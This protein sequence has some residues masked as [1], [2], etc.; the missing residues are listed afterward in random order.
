MRN[1]RC[2]EYYFGSSDVILI[3]IDISLVLDQEKIDTTSQFVLEQVSRWHDYNK[4]PN[5]IPPLI[6][7]VF[8]KQDRI[9][10]ATRKRNEQVLKNLAKNG[11]IGNFLFISTKTGEGMAELKQ[12]IFDCDIKGHGEKVFP[13][14]MQKKAQ[15]DM[16]KR[17]SLIKPM[18]AQSYDEDDSDED[19]DAKKFRKRSKS[20]K[21]PDQLI[22]ASI[23]SKK[24]QLSSGIDII[25]EE[26]KEDSPPKRL[27]NERRERQDL[28]GA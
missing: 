18:V 5:V 13:K 26:E 10:K 20:T 9:Q 22:E 6:V 3:A 25:E 27:K 15:K 14:S 19:P 11:I 23:K 24:S 1:M 2:S 17:S 21:V 12:A 28:D 7:H 8:T 16:Q 4:F